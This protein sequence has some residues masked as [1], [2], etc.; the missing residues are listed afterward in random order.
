[1]H[2]PEFASLPDD[3]RLWLLALDRPTDP[4]LI[5]PELEATLARWRHKGVQYQAAWALLHQ[6]V[7]AIAEP[8]LAAQPSGCAIDGMLRSVH[9][10]L[11]KA[12]LKFH[13]NPARIPIFHVV[14]CGIGVLGF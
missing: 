13:T 1:M 9:Q 5:A 12:G 8:T 10:L 14:F 6:Q 11:G 2:L 4:A 3:A 7:L